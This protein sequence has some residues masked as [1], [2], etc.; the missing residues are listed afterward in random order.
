M[1]HGLVLFLATLAACG[2]P[3]GAT[4]AGDVDTEPAPTDDTEPTDGT[5]PPID[6][7]VTATGDTG[8]TTTPPPEVDC[9]AITLPAVPVPFTTAGEYSS[10]EDFDFDS[11]GYVGVVYQGNLVGKN[12]YGDNLLIAPGVSDWPSGTRVLSTGDWVVADTGRG[13]VVRIDVATGAQT[14]LT[15]SLAW[16]NG[17][18]VGEGDQLFVTDFST[19]RVFRV[20][21]YDPTDTEVIGM[22]LSQANGIV[23]SPDELSLYVIE[24]WTAAI[25]AF[26]K[27]P[28]GGGWTGPRLVLYEAGG[29][30]QGLNADACGNLYVTDASVAAQSP[31]LRVTPDGTPEVLVMLPTGYPPNLRFGSGIDGWDRET[32]YVSDRDQGRLFAIEAGVPGKPPVWE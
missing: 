24:S 12:F 15:S 20:N 21:A 19:G 11:N 5:T 14:V 26:D 16:P 17:I 4:T 8:G 29:D 23:L 6:T 27:D 18:E 22:G 9:A 2:G 25:V 31:I 1:R 10:S 3:S 30:Y 13:A 7:Y 28:Y 32:L